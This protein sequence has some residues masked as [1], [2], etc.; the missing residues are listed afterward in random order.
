MRL[1]QE[2]T[3]LFSPRKLKPPVEWAFDNCVLRDNISE[4]PGALKI[5]PYA[6][7]PMNALVDPMVNK[8]LYVGDHNLLK[9][10][11]CMQELHISFLSSRKILCGSCRQQRMLGTLQR[12]VGF[13]S[14]KTVNPCS[15]NV[16]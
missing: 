9:R 10:Q 12:V 5:F 1:Q 6:K 13:H 7:E 14:S 11:P 8:V 2:V 15:H 4:L 16:R 3:K